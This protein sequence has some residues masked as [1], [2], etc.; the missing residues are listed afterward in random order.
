MV[1]RL[2]QVLYWGLSGIAAISFALGVWVNVI[3]KAQADWSTLGVVA[4]FSVVVWLV[5]RACLY[6]LA[7]K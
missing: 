4:V 2:G 1:A 7:G 5:G 6:V 3:N